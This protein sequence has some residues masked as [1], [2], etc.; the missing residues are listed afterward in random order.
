MP[1]PVVQHIHLTAALRI[2]W[3]IENLLYY[4]FVYLN[5]QQGKFRVTK[6]KFDE[7][8]YV[9]VTQLRKYWADSTK[10]D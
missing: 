9:Q 10:F 1:K 7:P 5:E 4:D 3:L 8:G 2:D 6:D